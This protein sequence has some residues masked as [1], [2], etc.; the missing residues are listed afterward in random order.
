MLSAHLQEKAKVYRS[1]IIKCC[2]GAKGIEDIYVNVKK[3][4]DDA[5]KGS[6][7][8]KMYVELDQYFSEVASL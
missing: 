6:F 3:G 5:R 4:L 2:R 1:E 7:V 8:E